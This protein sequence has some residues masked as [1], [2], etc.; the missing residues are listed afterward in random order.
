MWRGDENG[1]GT[2]GPG[3]NRRQSAAWD[4]QPNGLGMGLVFRCGGCWL[5]FFPFGCFLHFQ[6]WEFWEKPEANWSSSVRRQL[7]HATQPAG[8]SRS[9]H[10]IPN[11]GSPGHQ[12]EGR[13]DAMGHVQFCAKLTLNMLPRPLLPY[14][15]HLT[16]S[17]FNFYFVCQSTLSRF[18]WKITNF[19]FCY[20]VNS[21]SNSAG[22]LWQRSNLPFFLWDFSLYFNIVICVF[23]GNNFYGKTNR[24]RAAH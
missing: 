10:Q 16:V 3:S 19:P 20:R 2:L 5:V 21:L 14:H 7:I 11:T 24:T 1:R 15:E 22:S 4:F 13:E 17:S 6:K 18:Y 9:K 12:G 23:S 8:R